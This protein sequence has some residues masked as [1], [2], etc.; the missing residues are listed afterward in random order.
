[1]TDEPDGVLLV[2]PAEELTRSATGDGRLWTGTGTNRCRA[3][4]ALY[5]DSE[6]EYT[7]I[8]AAFRDRT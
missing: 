3:R 6:T 7:Q 4:L 5:F 2:L 1:V 8:M